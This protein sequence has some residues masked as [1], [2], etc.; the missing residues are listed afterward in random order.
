MPIV[1]LIFSNSVHWNSSSDK[2]MQKY[3]G[4]ND[5]LSTPFVM[6]FNDKIIV[7]LPLPLPAGAPPSI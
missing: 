3:P 7:S 6:L 2:L 4:Y 5:H 1:I